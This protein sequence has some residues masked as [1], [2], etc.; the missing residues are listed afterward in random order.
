MMRMRRHVLAF[1]APFIAAGCAGPKPQTAVAATTEGSLDAE[2][3][4]RQA[5]NRLTFGA[6]DQDV[7]EIERVGV[8]SWVERQLHPERIADPVADSVLGLLEITH[9][10]AFELYAD[11]PQPNEYG[12]PAR[13]AARHGRDSPEGRG[14]LGQSADR[15]RHATGE[16]DRGG[17]AHE[18]AAEA[19]AARARPPSAS[20]NH[21]FSFVPSRATGSCSR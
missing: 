14:R 16:D 17:G 20:C 21:R 1:P 13:Q 12:Y 9:K 4:A 10:T 7:A 19:S 3:R 6:R 5:L 11:H 8:S 15:R 2:S 18:G